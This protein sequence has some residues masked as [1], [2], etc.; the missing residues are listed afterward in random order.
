MEFSYNDADYR[1]LGIAVAQNGHD[2]G[3]DNHVVLPFGIPERAEFLIDLLNLS[4]TSNQLLDPPNNDWLGLDAARQHRQRRQDADRDASLQRS[5]ET[6]RS[7]VAVVRRGYRRSAPRVDDG[8]TLQ[9]QA[10]GGPTIAANAAAAESAPVPACPGRGEHDPRRGCDGSHPRPG[11]TECLQWT[12]T[13]SSGSSPPAAGTR[14]P[15]CRRPPR[16]PSRQRPVSHFLDG[17]TPGVEYNIRV[18]ATDSV[19]D[20]E[21]SNEITYTKPAVAQQSL[22][23][24]P[25]EG[26]P[27][28]DGIPE[29]GQTLSVDTTGIVDVDGLDDVA[30]Q[31]QW[32]ADD[33]DIAGSTGATYSVV[34]G[35]VGKGH[36]GACRLRRRRGQR[37][38]ADQ[39]AHRGDGGGPAAPVGH[40]GR[41]H[42]DADLWRGSWTTGSRWGTTP[43]AVN[44]NGSPRSLSG[45]AVGGSNVLLLLSSAV[46]AGDTVTVDYTAPNG[47]DFIRD[48]FGRK[49]ASFSGQ[50]V[51]NDTASAREDTVKGPE[52][53]A[54]SL[55][56]SATG[57]P[58]ITGTAQVEETLTADTTG[59]ADNDGLDDAAFAYQWLA[60]DAEIDGA[61]AGTYTLVAADAGR[62]IRVRVTFTDDGDNEETLTSAATGAVVAAVVRPPLTASTNDVPSSHGRELHI[63]LRAAF[64]RGVLHKLQDPAGPRLH[65]DRG[66]GD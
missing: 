14:P 59:I 28:I 54:A 42:P 41:R 48:T 31:Y 27:R 18:I 5:Q 8:P 25:A 4:G 35:D 46:E 13:R 22:S 6:G 7:L 55:N 3:A 15:T 45:V 9:A 16:G 61:T 49:A 36:Q 11:T 30:F 33:A 21:P 10:D 57:L 32:L 20:S 29:V 65:G 62:A 64:Q 12:A 2:A 38:D 53:T 24:S 39:R 58:N 17:L 19:G 44:V 63:H 26:E 37:G 1:L 40:S 47:Q 66:R 52:D 34:S 43:F 60:D 51:T 23:N 50:A 56:T